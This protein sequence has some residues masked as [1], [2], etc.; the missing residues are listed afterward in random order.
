[1]AFS[2]GVHDCH[3]PHQVVTSEPLAQL[4]KVYYCG[5]LMQVNVF[6]DN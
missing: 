1:V 6:F 4:R 5:V 2:K 3:S